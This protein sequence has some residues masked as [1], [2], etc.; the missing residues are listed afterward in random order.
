MN[1]MKHFICSRHYYPDR[2]EGA[3][4][5]AVTGKFI[6]NTLEPAWKGNQEN[7][8]CIPDGEYIFVAHDG[9]LQKD[10]WAALNVPGDRT[11]IC[12][13]VANWVRELKGCF[14]AGFGFGYIEN[15]QGKDEYGIM[16]SAA[17]ISFLKNYVGR[18]AAG[19]LLPFRLTIC[20]VI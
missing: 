3:W 18:D 8:S 6:I 9:P 14:A 5:D 4:H 13:H 10:V 1:E 2:V 7:I 15:K 16:S 17:A 12:L 11:G 19:K 20:K